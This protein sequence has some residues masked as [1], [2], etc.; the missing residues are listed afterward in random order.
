MAAG[1][2]LH[3]PH[4]SHLTPPAP[5]ETRHKFLQPAPYKLHLHPVTRCLRL[6]NCG[7]TAVFLGQSSRASSRG[8]WEPAAPQRP[9]APAAAARPPQQHR[10]P[11]RGR[12]PASLMRMILRRNLGCE[13]V[14]TPGGGGGLGEGAR[15]G[16]GR[17]HGDSKRGKG[18]G[19]C[20]RWRMGAVGVIPESEPERGWGGRRGRRR[21]FIWD[22]SE[23]EVG[24]SRSG[25]AWRGVAVCRVRCAP[26]QTI[27]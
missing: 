6:S 1:L 5:P 12:L 3:V 18:K 4:T 21:V 11:Q 16:R 26:A 24:L 2:S 9:R 14:R 7:H 13:S 20:G 8:G 22:R 10:V 17:C 15:Q 23:V 27:I 19:L 25:A